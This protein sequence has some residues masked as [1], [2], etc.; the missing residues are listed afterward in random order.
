MQDSRRKPVSVAVVSQPFD[1]VYPPVDSSVPMQSVFLSR[2]LVK[3]GFHV[4][5][6][7]PRKNDA[8]RRQVVDGVHYEYVSERGSGFVNRAMLRLF[9]LSR[10]ARRIPFHA[11]VLSDLRYSVDVALRIRAQRADIVH[12]HTFTNFI[13]V[14]RAFNPH[15]RIVLHMHSE[16]VAQMDRAIMAP[17]VAATALL[18]SC[19]THFANVVKGM[20]PEAAARTTVLFNGVDTDYLSPADDDSVERDAPRRLLFLG[21]VSPEKG[22]HDLIDAFARIAHEFPDTLLDIVGPAASA[23]RGFTV[24][25]SEDPKVRALAAFYD[26]EARLGTSYLDQLKSRVPAPLVSRVR[27]HGAATR[28]QVRARC[29]EAAVLINP[30]LLEMFG[31]TVTEAMACGTAV[32]AARVGGMKETVV[33]GQTG[34]LVEPGAP[35]QLADAISRLLHDDAL[36]RSM[37]REACVRA[38]AIV[39]W[40]VLGHQLANAYD[41]LVSQ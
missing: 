19:S 38:R 34:V 40:Q 1:L 14:I 26:A 13:P 8:V 6:Y 39:S 17:R 5:V 20:F 32:V 24:D 7:A 18:V 30:S 25:V 11:S 41:A 37:G 12:V 29:R 21:R 2:E 23:P 22:V 28:D 31:G 10:A 15:A 33:D 36:R 35:D 9:R 4:V 27:F 3:G 16:W